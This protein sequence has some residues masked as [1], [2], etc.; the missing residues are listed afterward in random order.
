MVSVRMSLQAI[1]HTGQCAAMHE[2]SSHYIGAKVNQEVIVDQRR[3]PL[4]QAR[5]AEL[6]CSLAVVAPTECFRIGICCS[7][8]QEC[9]DHLSGSFVSEFLSYVSQISVSAYLVSKIFVIILDKR[10]ILILV[11]NTEIQN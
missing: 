8:S 4:P 3:G 10:R 9:D 2:S 11:F 1:A 6:S 7:S 5:A